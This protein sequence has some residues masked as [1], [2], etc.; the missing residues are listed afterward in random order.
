MRALGGE[1]GGLWILHYLFA[2]A[3]YLYK[4]QEIP[5]QKVKISS[6]FTKI[7][8]KSSASPSSSSHVSHGST[9][10]QA[11]SIMW[12]WSIRWLNSI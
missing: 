5:Q 1:G 8:N 12:W 3:V 4:M 6:Y 2:D 11:M 9:T 10:K 7:E